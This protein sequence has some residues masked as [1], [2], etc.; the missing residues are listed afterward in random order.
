MGDEGAGLSVREGRL[1]ASPT[2]CIAWA[3]IFAALLGRRED[4]GQGRPE[5]GAGDGGRYS[6]LDGKRECG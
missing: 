2:I 3:M 6:G 4:A 5:S 1:S